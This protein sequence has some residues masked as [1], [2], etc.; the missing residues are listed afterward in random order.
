MSKEKS[1]LTAQANELVVSVAL[2]LR[3][4]VFFFFFFFHFLSLFVFIVSQE[5]LSLEKVGALDF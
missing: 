5:R 3:M 2:I 1:D 4:K